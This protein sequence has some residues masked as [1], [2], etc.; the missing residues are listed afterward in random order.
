MVLNPKP[1]ILEKKRPAPALRGRVNPGAYRRSPYPCTC[2]VPS[3]SCTFVVPF[4]SCTCV[5]PTLSLHR[6]PPYPAPA[7]QWRPPYPAP[8]WRPPYPCTCVPR[9]PLPL[10]ILLDPPPP[11][12][13]PQPPSSSVTGHQSLLI[14]DSHCHPLSSLALPPPAS[15]SNIFLFRLPSAPC[16]PPPTPRTRRHRRRR[17]PRP[18]FPSDFTRAR[19]SCRPEPRRAGEGHPSWQIS[20]SNEA[21]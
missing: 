21:G 8:A 9:P 16:G 2:M 10:V 3:L 12:T 11:P 13:P 4:L 6:R 19:R 17:R 14:I 5:A 7:W 20:E 1:Y 15:E 18:A